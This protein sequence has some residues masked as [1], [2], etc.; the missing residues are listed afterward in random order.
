MK[1]KGACTCD[2][3]ST[4]WF[5]SETIISTICKKRSVDIDKEAY[6]T[7]E[8]KV[9]SWMI[10]GKKM[11]RNKFANLEETSTSESKGS[12]DSKRPMQDSLYHM[13]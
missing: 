2:E 4:P 5:S 6:G 9:A 8:V 10:L 1:A 11:R 12:C 3:K 7:K 13:P